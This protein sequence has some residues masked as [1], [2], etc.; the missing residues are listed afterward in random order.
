MNTLVKVRYF[1]NNMLMLWAYNRKTGKTDFLLG[2]TELLEVLEDNK[3][4]MHCFHDCGS[5]ATMYRNGGMLR[6]RITHVRQQFNGE[7]K[8]HVCAFGL[9]VEKLA[10]M[11]VDGK[12]FR[13]LDMPEPRQSRVVFHGNKCLDFIMSD[14]STRRAFGKF[15][16]SAFEWGND[17]VIDVYKDGDAGFFFRTKSGFPSCG[18]IILHTA[19]AG[20]SGHAG[21]YFSVHT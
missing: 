6:V 5:F 7:I 8:G 16:R 19:N 15:M 12:E 1:N 13:H 11:L 20:K 4:M 10:Q 9:P 3:G 21:K 18:G 14:K 17:E 2:E